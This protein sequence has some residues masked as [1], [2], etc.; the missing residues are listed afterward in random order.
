MTIKIYR[1]RRFSLTLL[2]ILLFIIFTVLSAGAAQIRVA[3]A[4]FVNRA[5]RPESALVS[6]RGLTDI[7]TKILA[8][9][10]SNI[11]VSRSKS[12]Q[13][14]NGLR[15]EDFVVAGKSANCQYIILGALKQFK[16]DTSHTFDNTGFLMS[17]P[18]LKAAIYEYTAD[19]DLRLIEVETG[20][21]IFS[22][23]GTGRAFYTQDN[24]EAAKNP[25]SQKRI[26][27]EA[28]KQEQV[29]NKALS[30]AAS[31]SAEKICAFLTGEYPEV[32][33]V[34]VNTGTA[35]KSKRKSSKTEAA[36]SS[37]T[38][39]I[40]RGTLSGVHEKTLFKIFYEG[41]EIFDRNGKSLGREK[42]NIAVAEVITP[43]ADY[44]TASVTGGIFTNIRIGT[45]AEQ[46]T[47]EEADLIIKSND[48]VKNR[49]SEVPR[50]LN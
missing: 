34:Q 45:K 7:F 44:S 39:T 9:S 23:S 42:L 17:I 33:S 11:E 10:S 35:R 36:K 43:H 14:L 19:L 4:D 12:F 40:N 6:M 50:N 8:S 3:A 47:P 15:P 38:V 49:L 24:K 28:N 29:R 25:Y 32:S 37:G 21:I 1:I 20:K 18:V 46:I 22:S 31:M 30:A 2:I 27:D 5:N 26:Q 16:S 48:F 41:E 13:A